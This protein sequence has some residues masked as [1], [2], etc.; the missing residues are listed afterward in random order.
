MAL[1]SKFYNGLRVT[2]RSIVDVVAGRALM[3]KTHEA[4][5]EL[6]EELALNNYYYQWHLERSMPKIGADVMEL[7]YIALLVAQTTKLSK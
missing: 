7:D 5:S 1:D 3:S 4:T 6:L 2:N